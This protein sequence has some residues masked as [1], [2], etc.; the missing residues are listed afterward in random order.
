M[1]AASQR[2]VLDN[3]FAMAS[4]NRITVI[5]IAH[6][7]ETAVTY[8][9]KILVMDRGSVAEFDT[10]TRLLTESPLDE[11]VTKKGL[12]ASMVKTLQ[13]SQQTRIV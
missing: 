1:D 4:E 3:L 12:F 6:R 5:M 11:E 7:L 2:Q 8:S 13:V 9:D 10:A